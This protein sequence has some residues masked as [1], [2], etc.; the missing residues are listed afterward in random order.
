MTKKYKCKKKSFNKCG[1]KK[2][3]KINIFRVINYFLLSLN[4]ITSLFYSYQI[5]PC[6]KVGLFFFFILYLIRI[7]KKCY[8]IN[9][10]I[11]YSSLID[12]CVV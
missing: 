7:I 12:Q 2:K 9:V 6:V 5:M 1:T 8:Q 11:N 3:R 4:R 10:V